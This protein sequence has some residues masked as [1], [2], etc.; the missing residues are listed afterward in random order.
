MML[1]DES[2]LSAR[3]VQLVPGRA[4]AA[5]RPVQARQV[6]GVRVGHTLARLSN[7]RRPADQIRSLR[8][9]AVSNLRFRAFVL[10]LWVF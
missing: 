8:Q 7:V 9:S 2:K 5:N 4:R 1:C 10:S 3:P 6:G